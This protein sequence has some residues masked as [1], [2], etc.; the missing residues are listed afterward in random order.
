MANYDARCSLALP[1]SE[2]EQGQPSTGS[3]DGDGSDSKDEDNNSGNSSP[4]RPLRTSL[5]C[6]NTSTTARKHGL[7]VLKIATI[8]SQHC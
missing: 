7:L 2:I 8:R 5:C 1:A 3:D 6:K 4:V